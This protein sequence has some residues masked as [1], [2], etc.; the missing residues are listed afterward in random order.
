MTQADKQPTLNQRSAEN[1]P[2]TQLLLDMDGG[3]HSIMA[4]D[5]F[6]PS[7]FQT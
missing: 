1:T 5:R 6:F 4:F 2:N 7:S 3:F